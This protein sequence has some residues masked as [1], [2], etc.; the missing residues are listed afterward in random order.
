ML[1]VYGDDVEPPL[2]RWWKRPQVLSCYFCDLA[3]LVA[4]DSRL[5]GLYIARCAGLNL[6]KTKN[7]G[8]PPDQVDFSMAARRTIVTCHD[9]VAQ[10]AQVEVSMLLALRAGPQVPR[11]FIRWKCVLRHPIQTANYASREESGEH[12]A[13][14]AIPARAKCDRHHK[15]GQERSPAIPG[16]G[17]V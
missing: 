1:I 16:M 12:W 6:N 14:V 7:I 9:H 10:L 15:E 11:L 13:S 4:I 5:G 3:P 2:A 17:I 8:V